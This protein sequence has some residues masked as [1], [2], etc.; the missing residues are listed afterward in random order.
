MNKIPILT[1]LI[2][3]LS[4]I[5]LLDRCFPRSNIVIP[6]LEPLQQNIQEEKNE[7]DNDDS[8]DEINYSTIC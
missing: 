5:L 4:S 7:E 8:D 3:L 1:I 2:I 6:P